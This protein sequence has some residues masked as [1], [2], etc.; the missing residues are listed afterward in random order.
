MKVNVLGVEK[1]C[2]N[3]NVEVD[4]FEFLKSLKSSICGVPKDAYIK[5]GSVVTCEDVSY[6]GRPTYEYTT[7]DVSDLDKEIISK[8]SELEV[9]L[10]KKFY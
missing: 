5:D 3:V 1:V 8:I 2:R 6:H 4:P 7:Y 10:R 9:I